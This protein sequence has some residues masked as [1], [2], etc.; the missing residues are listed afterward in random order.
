MIWISRILTFLL[1]FFL[2]WGVAFL[3]VTTYGWERVWHS[4]HGPADLGTVEFFRLG[5]TPT[6]D[7]V[8][9]C[10]QSLCKTADLDRLSP[11]YDTDALTLRTAFVKMLEQETSLERVDNEADPYRLR[12]VQRSRLL[13]RPDTISVRFF[14]F[15]DDDVSALALYGRG[16]VDIPYWRENP[17]R[18]DR[19]LDRLKGLEKSAD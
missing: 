17:R 10:P 14:E 1:G 11:V 19:W 5:K 18:A 13:R 8:L 9:I 15:N 2:L 3:V 12:Y 7:E 6:R 16:Q 4:I